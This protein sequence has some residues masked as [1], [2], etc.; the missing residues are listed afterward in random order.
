MLLKKNNTKR[1]QYPIQVDKKTLEL[2]KTL[3]YQ[4]KTTNKDIVSKA[5][6]LFQKVSIFDV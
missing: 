2:I 1:V 3:A 4:N 5:V 6:E